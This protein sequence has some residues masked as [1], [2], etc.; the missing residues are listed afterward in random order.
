MHFHNIFKQNY[1]EQINKKIY[2]KSVSLF[3]FIETKQPPN[4]YVTSHLIN[5]RN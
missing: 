1:N 2:T 5:K 4:N 3:N